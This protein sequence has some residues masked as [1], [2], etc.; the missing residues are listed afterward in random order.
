M[1][2]REKVLSR[3]I[4]KKKSGLALM[5]VRNAL[6]IEMK[7]PLTFDSVPNKMCVSINSLIYEKKTREESE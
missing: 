3:L 6:E 4:N 5:F 2:I 7:Y 1:L